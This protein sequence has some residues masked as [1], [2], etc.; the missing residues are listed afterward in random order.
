MKKLLLLLCLFVGAACFAQDTIAYDGPAVIVHK[1]P[2]LDLL[3][4][5]QAY[6]NIT[7]K[8][9]SG[10][11]MRGYRLLVINTNSRDE[12]IAAKTKIYTHFPDQKAYLTYQSPF[13]KLKAGNYQTRDEAKRYQELMNTIFPKGV[14]I[15]SD[16]IEVKPE[17][18]AEESPLVP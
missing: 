13:F 7:A 18:E 4:K 1:D 11:T 16:T 6:I 3:V 5:K 9:A 10:H 17:K 2:R 14:F 12:A 8:K 15:I